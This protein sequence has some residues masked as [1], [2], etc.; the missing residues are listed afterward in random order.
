MGFEHP[1]GEFLPRGALN[2]SLACEIEEKR[3]I[4]VEFIE[5]STLLLCDET[6]PGG[7]GG[8]R[9]GGRKGGGYIYHAI[10]CTVHNI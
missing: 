9:E 5:Y 4:V 6:L 10:M 2:E 1:Q 7:K 3:V 8:E